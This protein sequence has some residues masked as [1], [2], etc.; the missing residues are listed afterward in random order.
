MV[1]EHSF[2][3]IVVSRDEETLRFDRADSPLDPAID[4]LNLG[5]QKGEAITVTTSMVMMTDDDAV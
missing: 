5:I 4:R 1:A 3:N 2:V